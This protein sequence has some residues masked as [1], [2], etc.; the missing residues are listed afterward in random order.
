MRTYYN[1][2]VINELSWSSVLPIAYPCSTY[3]GWCGKDFSHQ[4]Q[5]CMYD[6]ERPNR[7][8]VDLSVAYCSRSC[9]EKTI[10]NRLHMATLNNYFEEEATED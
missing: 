2:F 8:I 6:I 4:Y 9:C 3:C 5:A 7:R 10:D 1:N